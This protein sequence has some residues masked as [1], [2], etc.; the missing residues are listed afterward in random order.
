MKA[1]PVD[2]L[3]FQALYEFTGGLEEVAQTFG[4]R[5]FSPWGWSF[6]LFC[7]DKKKKIIKIIKW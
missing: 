5:V 1:A 3:P 6:A 2:L 7:V 4:H